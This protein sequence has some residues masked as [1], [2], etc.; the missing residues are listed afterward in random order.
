MTDGPEVGPIPHTPH[1]APVL[2]NCPSDAG[3]VRALCSHGAVGAMGEQPD[4]RA[5][6]S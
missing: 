5:L 4:G 2:Q 1:A 3:A 6:L